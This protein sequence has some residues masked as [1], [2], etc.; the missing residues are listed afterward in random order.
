[1]IVDVGLID[2][3]STA[4]Q[5]G[6][7]PRGGGTASGV[8]AAARALGM[9][10]DAVGQS[11]RSLRARAARLGYAPEAGL[12]NPNPEGFMIKRVSNLRNMETGDL[13]LQW[14][15]M[16]PDQGAGVRAD[17]A[18]GLPIFLPILWASPPFAPALSGHAPTRISWS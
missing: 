7:H 8:R 10:E 12:T 17:P 1:M 16:E 18:S 11:L 14:Q 15:I 6:L 3:R 13:K 9:S 2:L 5:E 4:K